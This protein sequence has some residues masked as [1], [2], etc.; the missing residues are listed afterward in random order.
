ME[1]IREAME[2]IVGSGSSQLTRIILTAEIS[3][4][5]SLGLL[6][7]MRGIWNLDPWAVRLEGRLAPHQILLGVGTNGPGTNGPGTNG[8]RINGPGT[9]GPGTNGPKYKVTAKGDSFVLHDSGD[10][11]S[12]RLLTFATERNLSYLARATP[13]FADGTF[14]VT[15]EQFYQLYTVHAVVNGVVELMVY[16]LLASNQKP[17]TEGSSMCCWAA[18]GPTALRVT[19]Q[20]LTRQKLTGQKLT[21]QKLTGQKLT[22]QKLTGQ[23]LTGQ[24][25]TRVLTD[26][27]KSSPVF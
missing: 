21:G 16:G 19:G 8:P 10:G 4:K 14:K 25:L 23:K 2:R 20:K 17:P 6:N 3:S 26:P 24:K 22:G 18:L 5:C 1:S 13:W 9:N 12:E 7:L 27:D 11:D 15:P